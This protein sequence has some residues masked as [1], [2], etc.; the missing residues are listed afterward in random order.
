MLLYVVL[1]FDQAIVLFDRRYIRHA[2]NIYSERGVH[3]IREDFRG[4]EFL[5]D[6]TIVLRTAV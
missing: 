5:I 2:V 1:L 3:N 6:Q 4:K